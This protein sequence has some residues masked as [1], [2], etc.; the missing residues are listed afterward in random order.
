M[1]VLGVLG[2]LG[3]KLAVFLENWLCKTWL[4]G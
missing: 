2:G 1:K 3:A 4:H